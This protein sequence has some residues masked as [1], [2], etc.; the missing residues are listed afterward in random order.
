[1]LSPAEVSA[2]TLSF[3]AL[4]SR[5]DELA[6]GF[7]TKLFQLDPSLRRLFHGDMR[8]QGEKL[9]D[10]LAFIVRHLGNPEALVPAVKELGTRHAGYRVELSHFDTVGVALIGAMAE[11]LKDGFTAEMKAAWEKAY[12][13]LAEVMIEAWRKARA[14]L[15][16][17][18]F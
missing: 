5:A 16:Q 18:S 15:G 11:I 3:A 7:Y 6:R 10:M 17:E 14:T 8:A 2:V 13:Y 12:G 1:M 9:V 4:E